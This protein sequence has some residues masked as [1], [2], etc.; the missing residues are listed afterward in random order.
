MNGQYASPEVNVH[1][2]F[3]IQFGKYDFSSKLPNGFQNHLAKGVKTIQHMN[4]AIFVKGKTVYDM[5]AIFA[6]IL[7]LGQ[8]SHCDT[9]SF[10]CGKGKR[11]TT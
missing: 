4:K 10:P 11:L 5:E 6:H 2:A 1:N 8:Q 3:D 7:V 9:M